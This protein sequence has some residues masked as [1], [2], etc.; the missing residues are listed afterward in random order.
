MNCTVVQR[1]LLSITNPE[2]VPSALRAHLA[3]CSACREWHNQLVLVER[4]IP[5]LPIPLSNGK[6]KLMH[7]LLQESAMAGAGPSA[8]A[9]PATHSPAVLP[10]TYSARLLPTRTLLLGVAAA[11]LLL[12]LGCSHDPL[13]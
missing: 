12:V 10:G 1:R 7:R 4:H 11:L 2:R 9:P 13:R 8:A 5:L 6:A 3:Y